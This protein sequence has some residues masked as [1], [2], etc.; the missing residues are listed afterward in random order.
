MP[1]I[2]QLPAGSA[3][4]DTD[5]LPVSQAGIARRVTRT[6]LLAGVQPQ[7]ALPAGVLLGRASAGTGGPEGIAV[8]ANLA[9]QD[10]ILS[11]AA[12]PYRVGGLPA[13]QAP[14][15]A[16]LVPLA[17]AGGDAA[18]AYAQFMAGLSALPGIDASRLLA[19]AAGGSMARPLSDML[20]DAV[21][22]EAFGAVGDGVTDDSAALGAA[23]ASG[24]PVRLGAKTYV[25]NGQWTIAVPAVLL[26]VPGLTVLRRA[27]QAG[28][29]AWISVQGA[30]FV[31]SGI[32]FDA[33]RAA[34]AQE[35][36]GVLVT[37]AC[38]E[39]E[40]VECSFANAQGTTLGSGLAFLSSDP[41]VAQHVVR[42]CEMHGNAAHGVWVQAV[43]GV[44]VLDCRA[45]DNGLYGICLDYADPGFA[46]K[47]RAGQVIGNRCWANQRGISVGNYNAANTTPPVWGNANPDAI[48]V[49]VAA[50]DCHDNAVYGIAVSGQAIVVQGNLL[51]NNGSAANGGG[52]ILA[53]ASSSRIAGNL[54]SGGAQYG[55][56]SGGSLDCDIA[57][58]HVSGAVVG[59]NAGGSQ[60]VRL[61]HNF[62]Q[63]CGWAVTAY[64]VE[65]DGQGHN[66]GLATQTLAIL[67][68]W[69]CIPGAG[70]GGIYLIDAPQG[71]Q[72]MRN[73]FVGTG[74][75]QPSQALWAHTDGVTVEGNSWNDAQR[76]ICN[77]GA[78]GGVQQVRFPDIADAVM[79][80][81]APSGVQSMLGQHQAA[82]QGQIAYVKVTS[83]GV[84]YTQ[85]SVAVFG[86]GNG[87]QAIAYVSGG[88][89]IGVAVTN[90][91]SGYGGIGATA[92]VTITG[93]GTGAAATASVGLPV[94]EERRLRVACNCAVRFARVGSSPFQEN[95]TLYD[96]TIPANTVVEW[97]GTWGAWR[98]VQFAGADY[99]V[100]A[101]DGSLMLRSAGTGDVTL[102]PGGTGRL[103][104][105]SDA[106]PGGFVS[107]LGH[108][109]PLGV[110]AA[111]P[112]SDY[113][114]LDGG[115]GGTLW[116]KQTGQD[117]SGWIAVA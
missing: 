9:L 6:Q 90:P 96:V 89:V 81:A 16:D 8:G 27:Q 75:A 4:A 47:I 50:N 20:S 92:T 61:A 49:L 59:L 45:H 17:Q 35:S 48:G 55:I 32:V 53:N 68:N 70:G 58:N 69:I 86:A 23:V 73:S 52:G 36:W 31:A 91:G 24:R 22:V 46:A 51:S 106:E 39:S 116:I 117:A 25:V 77:P 40:F 83:G 56:D 94:P 64:N 66:F 76:F 85:A 2:D 14:G 67:D 43:S 28:D 93:D 78:V 30:R 98:A 97:A 18:I 114:N 10:G 65:T 107:C 29:G 13:G 38:T 54:V 57:H 101:G 44:Q 5:E 71:V 37:A 84:G 110:V 60:R 111:P 99:L 62:V 79:I 82:M 105:A 87:A 41:A 113:R 63:Q 15:A 12:A 1:T 33:N 11:A 115:A 3:A 21:A 74:G 108:G 103:R 100:P 34:V 88:S 19:T 72:V 104:V 26:G 80:T 7:I 112:G 102:R 42:S 109:S 95:W